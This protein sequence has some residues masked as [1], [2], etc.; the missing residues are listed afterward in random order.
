MSERYARAPRRC[1]SRLHSA[2]RGHDYWSPRPGDARRSFRDCDPATR[3]YRPDLGGAAMWTPRSA[4]AVLLAATFAA[5]VV[6]ASCGGEAVLGPGFGTP[7]GPETPQRLTVTAAA[8][9]DRAGVRQTPELRRL[10]PLRERRT[11]RRRISRHT[12]IQR[13]AAIRRPDPGEPG[14]AMFLCLQRPEFVRASTTAEPD[15]R[16]R[17]WRRRT[18]RVAASAWPPSHSLRAPR[19]PPASDLHAAARWS[20]VHCRARRTVAARPV[21]RAGTV[22]GPPLL[23][24]AHV[25]GTPAASTPASS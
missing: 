23:R 22:P 20:P 9:V 4:R 10:R 11:P 15:A 8:G 1:H 7:L 21:H 19:N 12:S 25:R 3:A 17:G 13:R 18:V 14:S 16:F 5:N 6:F 2:W 24:F